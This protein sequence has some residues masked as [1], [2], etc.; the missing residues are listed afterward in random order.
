SELERA[1]A[2]FEREFKHLSAKEK[3][4]VDNERIIQKGLKYIEDEKKKIEQEKDVI[5][6]ARNLKKVLPQMERR[7][8]E[9]RRGIG[10]AEARLIGERVEPSQLKVFREREKELSVKE[11]GVHLEFKKLLENE[12]EVEQLEQRKEKAF[13]AYLREEVERVQQGKPGKEIMHPD[14]HAMIDDA[15]EKVMQGS[16]DEAI[17]MVA[18]VEVLVDRLQDA[19]QKRLFYYDIRDLKTSI[20]LASLT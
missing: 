3:H 14:I 13:S 15:R 18:E 5:Y 12:K 7:Y 16:I 10:K 17:R 20:K 2:E 11:E 19:S 4:V 6:R 9:L 1:K 8:S